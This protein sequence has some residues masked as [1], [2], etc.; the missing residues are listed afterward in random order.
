MY[1]DLPQN[2]E[3]GNEGSPCGPESHD[4]LPEALASHLQCGM[5][6]GACYHHLAAG[7]K[8]GRYDGDAGGRM[9]TNLP[10]HTA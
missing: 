8:G 5:Q 2:T 3:V 9:L 6:R 4:R 7:K 1:I 10:S